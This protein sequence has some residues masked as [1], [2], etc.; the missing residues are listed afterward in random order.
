MEVCPTK[1]LV[2][3]VEAEH[4]SKEWFIP[5]KDLLRNPEYYE[6]TGSDGYITSESYLTEKRVEGGEV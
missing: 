3:G 5:N 4:S 1:A 6:K 2:K